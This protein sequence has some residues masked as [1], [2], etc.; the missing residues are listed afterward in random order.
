MLLVS[1][2]ALCAMRS[3]QPTPVFPFWSTNL[4][5]LLYSQNTSGSSSEP[6]TWSS[7]NLLTWN[8][9]CPQL[10]IWVPPSIILTQAPRAPPEPAPLLPLIISEC[11]V[12]ALPDM[13][14][15][16]TWE[17]TP[18]GPMERGCLIYLY[19]CMNGISM[20]LQFFF[21]HNWLLHTFG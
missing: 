4:I 1:S 21:S 6:E 15:S 9:V 7:P 11:P 14:S 10:N 20:V 19:T 8:A 13:L 5:R 3:L 12:P 17:I 2:P 16:L 18:F